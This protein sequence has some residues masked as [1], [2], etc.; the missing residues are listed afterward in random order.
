[1]SNRRRK[2]SIYFQ[3]LFLPPRIIV[4]TPSNQSQQADS[5]SSINDASDEQT[6]PESPLPSPLKLVQQCNAVTVDNG[7]KIGFS[8][9]V[10]KAGNDIEQAADPNENSDSDNENEKKKPQFQSFF[11]TKR[12]LS[13]APL[14]ALRLNDKEMMAN[15][16]ES[17]SMISNQ[18]SITS[19]NSLASLLKEK[20]QMF[21]SMIRRKKETT[22]DIKIKAFVLTLFMIIVFLVG[23]AYV[24]YEQHV[25]SYLYFGR[26]QFDKD[27][28]V[29][30]IFDHR[31][32][33]IEGRL[34]RNIIDGKP[35]HCV[36]GNAHDGSLCIE[37][38][39]EARLYMNEDKTRDGCFT[40]RWQ[41]LKNGTYPTDCFDIGDKVH[42]FGGGITKKNDWPLSRGKFD[43]EPFI[44]GDARAQ[45]FSNALNR[46][47]ISSHSVSIRVDERTPLYISMNHSN[48]NEFCL[49]AMNDNFAFVNRMTPYPE[50]SYEICIAENMRKLHNMT[51]E[52]KLAPDGQ[53]SEADLKV[54]Y[55]LM[56]EP[57]WQIPASSF[58]QLTETV[59]FNYTEEVVAFSYMKPG[60]I[61]VNEFWQKEIGDFTVDTE[62]FQ[63]FAETIKELHKKGFRIVLT[64]QPFIST[65][66]KSFK[67]G[68]EKK[69][70]IYERLSERSIPALTRYKSAPS[71]GVLDITVN[72][73]WLLQKLNKVVKDYQID[74]F[75][76]DF[77][78]A[79]NMP[80]YYQC[81]RS[82]LNPDE[83]KTIFGQ[84]FDD[85]IKI[86]AYSGAITAPKLPSFL[87]LPPVNASWEGLQS[88]LPTALAYGVAGFPFIMA[89]AVGGD[90]Y[91]SG[92]DSTILSY[93]SL[94]QPQLP[95]QELF[96]RW[97]QLSTFLPSIRFSHLPEEYKSEKVT[98]VEK[99][100]LSIRET[101]V[102]PI[103]KKYINE[104]IYDG[105]PLIRPLWLL[106][107]IP[108]AACLEENEFSIGE[109]LIVAPILYRGV[110]KRTIYLPSG[111]WKDGIDGT[112][113]KGN[114]CL[115]QY[116]V[117]IHQVPYFIRIPTNS[118]S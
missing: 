76:L 15:E 32:K 51:V 17:Q 58:D 101:V 24:A 94:D 67:E 83:Y 63:Y 50:L 1:M 81:H 64:V 104:A 85:S 41:A 69:L 9:A 48:S 31:R 7:S 115:Y 36:N 77:G 11:R 2:P 106:D 84:K 33:F 111:L 100:L 35:F 39:S 10:T 42:W 29:F 82:L 65:D 25:L 57:V 18:N 4:H 91:V 34:G 114:T 43:F 37:W 90:Y 45:Q 112:T 16:F 54:V 46:H 3:E 12:R 14:P 108:D 95:D 19:V 78:T 53:L 89:G 56:E 21:P 93:H 107:S 99:E 105:K 118:T 6:P 52:K 44:T 71:T 86:M 66:S 117:P 27:T 72:V 80:H 96:I 8:A 5:Q 60:H 92:N 102:I 103:L 38:D 98:T 20:M 88:I 49:K 70:L 110:N 74:S 40:L 75:F 79:Y 59:I 30:R 116:S 97:Y 26:I 87:S 61:L 13:I 28:R 22:S 23:Y 113:R 62:R 47:F 109:D 55:S 73:S 68:V